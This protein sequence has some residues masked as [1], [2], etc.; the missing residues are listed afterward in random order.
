MFAVAIKILFFKINLFLS[1]SIYSILVNK[2]ANIF[3]SST[4]KDEF[5]LMIRNGYRSIPL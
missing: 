1:L 5:L 2:V 4:K 3:E